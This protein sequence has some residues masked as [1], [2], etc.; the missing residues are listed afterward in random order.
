MADKNEQAIE[1]LLDEN[2][3]NNVI[4]TDKDGKE[5]EFMQVALIPLKD[6]MYT[7]LKPISEIEGVEDDEVIIFKFTEDDEGT[8]LDVVVDQDII[9]KVLKEL[10]TLLK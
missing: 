7:I 10:N 9:D 2:N 3:R 1:Q 5:M 6:D 8:S 4:L